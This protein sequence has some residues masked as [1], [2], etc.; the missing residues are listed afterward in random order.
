MYGKERKKQF[1][2]FGVYK[3]VFHWAI[4]LIEISMKF[5]NETNVVVKSHEKKNKLD[6]STD[7][8]GIFS[9]PKWISYECTIDKI[10]SICC[11][12]L[13]AGERNWHQ[14]KAY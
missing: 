9:G 8:N 2:C 11:K 6:F 3:Y 1:C 12:Y 13:A 4:K 10:T 5:M 14:R 7:F